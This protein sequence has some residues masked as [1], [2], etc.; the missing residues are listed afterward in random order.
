MPWWRGFE[1][2]TEWGW[3][4]LTDDDQRA[5]EDAG[6]SFTVLA[7]LEWKGLMNA[8]EEAEAAI[9]PERWVNVRYEDLLRDPTATI[10]E[11]IEFAGLSWTGE[12]ESR[13]R[14]YRLDASR[15]EA[16]RGDLD[17][18]DV[19]SIEGVI[20]SRLRAWGYSLPARDG[21]SP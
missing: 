21:G 4:P 20:G 11:L 3:G 14:R 19:R 12:F 2:P 8:F 16:F 9:D 13:L 10:K 5:W 18:S 17:P 7:A 6:R 1:G 15:A